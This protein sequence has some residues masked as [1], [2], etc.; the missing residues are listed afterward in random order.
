ML[1]VKHPSMSVDIPFPSANVTDAPIK[2]SPVSESVTFPCKIPAVVVNVTN[3]AMTTVSVS[4]LNIILSFPF[5]SFL[6]LLQR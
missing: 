4:F 6:N 2:A 3:N 5:F 1:I